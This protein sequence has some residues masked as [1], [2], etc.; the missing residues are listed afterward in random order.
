MSCQLMRTVILIPLKS[1]ADVPLD[2]NK[3]WA[4]GVG[5]DETFIKYWGAPD[6]AST[7]GADVVVV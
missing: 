1:I 2:G 7:H 6:G 5:H 3:R 4:H